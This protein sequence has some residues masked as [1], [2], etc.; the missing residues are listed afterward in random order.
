MN[1]QSMFPPSPDK[2][3]AGMQALADAAIKLGTTIAQLA[4]DFMVTTF[5][6][7]IGS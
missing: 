1:P 7:V 6:F 3:I 5:R 4:V 2:I